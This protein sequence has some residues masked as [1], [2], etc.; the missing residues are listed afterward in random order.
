VVTLPVPVSATK[1]DVY[2]AEDREIVNV[3]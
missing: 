3:N 2:E 1:N